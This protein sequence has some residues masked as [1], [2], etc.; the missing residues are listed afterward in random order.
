[1]NTRA[2]LKRYAKDQLKGRW[3]LAI[4]GILLLD[5]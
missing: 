2:E 5:F 4:G 3:G 1:M